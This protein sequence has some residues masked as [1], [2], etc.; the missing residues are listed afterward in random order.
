MAMDLDRP[1]RGRIARSVTVVGL[2]LA[3]LMPASEAVAAL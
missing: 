2:V 3:S 1:S